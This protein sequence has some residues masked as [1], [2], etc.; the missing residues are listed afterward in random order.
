MRSLEEIKRDID[1]E[2][3]KFPRDYDSP[4]NWE[5][6]RRI[7]ELQD[8]LRAALTA[9]IPLERLEAICAAERDGRVVVLNPMPTPAAEGAAKPSCYYTEGAGQWCLGMAHENDDEPIPACQGCWYCI[10]I[11][12]ERAEA[13]AALAGAQEARP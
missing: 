13:D 10:T 4:V 12:E 3:S 1:A 5:I 11:A 6:E 7:N 2:F 8:E 9:S